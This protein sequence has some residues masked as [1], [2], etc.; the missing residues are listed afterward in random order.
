MGDIVVEWRRGYSTRPPPMTDAHP[1]W[2]LISL[3][4]R[5]RGVRIPETESLA[6]TADR[7][8]VCEFVKLFVNVPSGPATLGHSLCHSHWSSQGGVWVYL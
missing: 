1:H 4:A 2:P 5:Y 3:D 6:D 8:C 7:V